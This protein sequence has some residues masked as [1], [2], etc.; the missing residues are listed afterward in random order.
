MNFKRKNQVLSGFNAAPMN[1]IIFFLLLFFLLT[2]S[3]AIPTYLKMSLAKAQGENVVPSPFVLEVNITVD[4]KSY[5]G[6]DEIPAGDLPKRL[7]EALR[8]KENPVI[9]LRVDENA[10]WGEGV[11]VLDLAN[12]YKAKLI[13][14]TQKPQ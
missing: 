12:K 8:G 11:K 1:D 10:K 3:F 5:L 14:A 6:K 7:E 9:N 13:V 4:G 2:S